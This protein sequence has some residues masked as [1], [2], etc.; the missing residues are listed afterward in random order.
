M[1]LQQR[2]HGHHKLEKGTLIC[3]VAENAFHKMLQAVAP[4]MD[5]V[6]NVQ[7]GQ[8]WSEGV[9]CSGHW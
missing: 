9:C 7:R 3:E 1:D 6:Y 5:S 4:S 8:L 2:F